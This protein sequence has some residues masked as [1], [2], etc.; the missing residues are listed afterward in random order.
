M[1]TIYKY[2]LP[3]DDDINIPLPEGAVVLSVAMQ[4]QGHPK[5][6]AIV[7]PGSPTERRQFH[8]RG[9]GHPLGNVG[10]FV[11]TVLI[12]S[13]ALVFHLFEGA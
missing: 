11:G 3:I 10:R 6:W 8:W 9:T 5:I 13:G 2:D 4:D 1:K 7:E 12:H